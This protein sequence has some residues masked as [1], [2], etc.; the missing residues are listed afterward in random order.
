M[1]VGHHVQCAGRGDEPGEAWLCD[2]V[3]TVPTRKRATLRT[4]ARGQAYGPQSRTKAPT[5]E[6]C[7]QERA[8]RVTVPMTVV[9]MTAVRGPSQLRTSSSRRVTGVGASRSDRSAGSRWLR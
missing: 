7:G 9:A 2:S 6:N 5:L 4:A 8:P 3:L 1:T